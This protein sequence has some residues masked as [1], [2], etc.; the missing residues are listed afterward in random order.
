MLLAFETACNA[1]LTK[2]VTGPPGCGKST[3]MQSFRGLWQ[4]ESGTLQFLSE[5][6][7]LFVPQQV[8]IPFECTLWELLAYPSNRKVAEDAPKLLES[9]GLQHLLQRVDGDWTVTYS[10][11]GE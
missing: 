3:M 4:L 6:K 8:L 9:V 10:W 1:C 7:L 2:F 11:T 5:R